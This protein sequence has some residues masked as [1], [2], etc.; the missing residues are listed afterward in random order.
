MRLLVFSGALAG[1][2]ATPRAQAAPTRWAVAVEG[3]RC[4][5][6]LAPFR[7]EL[8]L[9]CDVE[10]GACAIVEE[11][12]DATALLR[13]DGAVEARDAAGRLLGRRPFGDD[14][15]SL[16]DAAGFIARSPFVITGPDVLV[17]PPVRAV[18]DVEVLARPREETRPAP[19]PRA[20]AGLVAAA[21]YG[22][23]TFLIIGVRAAAVVRAHE[24]VA[25]GV[26]FGWSRETNLSEPGGGETVQGGAAF[27]LGAPWNDDRFGLHVEGGVARA[28]AV[29]ASIGGYGKAT[30]IVQ[31]FTGW[32]RF[33][34]RPF[35]AF[36]LSMNSNQHERF[37]TALRFEFGIAFH[38]W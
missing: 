33:P 12:A 25:L 35:N 29:R 27:A 34:L 15:D 26:A 28:S 10:N 36:G 23:A 24:R 20:R 11:G 2:L 16:R 37:A 13:C 4:A 3:P 7:H 5:S 9:A 30:A 17:V 1:A 21:F 22:G 6:W 31:W 38:A 14:A 18:P 8:A 19:D 32:P